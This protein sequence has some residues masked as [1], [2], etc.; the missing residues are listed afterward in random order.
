MLFDE[1]ISLR[2]FLRAYFSTLTT[3]SVIF[4][5]ILKNIFNLSQSLGTYNKKL[6]FSV[7]LSNF[8]NYFSLNFSVNCFLVIQPALYSNGMM[9][10]ELLISNSTSILSPSKISGGSEKYTYPT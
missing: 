8:N 9:V 6:I 4:Q 3:W 1:K 10:F 2:I 5:N 7:Y